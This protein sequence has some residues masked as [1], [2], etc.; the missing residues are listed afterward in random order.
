MSQ[1]DYLFDGYNADPNDD[2]R[3]KALY[4]EYY[5]R[6]D[7]SD[8]GYGNPYSVLGE[9]EPEL[10]D[11]QQMQIMLIESKLDVFGSLSCSR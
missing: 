4:D 6:S 8:S 7:D 5:G 11:Y 3:L 10:S 1:D 2:P 9:E